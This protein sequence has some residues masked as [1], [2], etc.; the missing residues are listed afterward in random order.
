MISWLA[1]CAPPQNGC[2]RAVVLQTTYKDTSAGSFCN[3][4]ADC[5]AVGLAILAY[6]V[7]TVAKVSPSVCR[8]TVLGMGEFNY[9]E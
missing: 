5:G 7:A 9:K 2:K 6:D 1:K 3:R 4:C 8:K